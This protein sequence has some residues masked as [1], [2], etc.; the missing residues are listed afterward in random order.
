MKKK[1]FKNY[2]FFR[3]FFYQRHVTSRV[4]K[5]VDIL[6]FDFLNKK[7]KY[8]FFKTALLDTCRYRVDTCRHVFVNTRVKLL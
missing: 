3:Y 4:A 7:K 5:R 6:I 8:F 1:F 2:N